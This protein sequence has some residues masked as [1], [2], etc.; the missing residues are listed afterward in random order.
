M[1]KIS[2]VL[3]TLLF[4]LSLPFYSNVAKAAE[5]DTIDMD[6]SKGNIVYTTSEG[7]TVVQ[8]GNTSFGI[9]NSYKIKDINLPISEIMLEASSNLT[10]RGFDV[11]TPIQI[12]YDDYSSETINLKISNNG[13]WS[14]LLIGDGRLVKNLAVTNGSSG[15]VTTV[16][17]ISI[18]LGNQSYTLKDSNPALS[19]PIGDAPSIGNDIL[20]LN[21]NLPAGF[22]PINKIVESVTVTANSWTAGFGVEDG[23]WSP[24]FPATI[25]FYID[26]YNYKNVDIPLNRFVSTTKVDIPAEYKNKVITKIKFSSSANNRIRKVDII[27]SEVTITS[28]KVAPSSITFTGPSI[29]QLKVMALMSTGETKDISKDPETEYDIDDA[30]VASVSETGLVTLGQAAQNGDTAV[31]EIQSGEVSATCNLKVVLT[32]T[33]SIKSSLSSVVLSN[34]SGKNTKQLKITA[35]TSSNKQIVVTNKATYKVSNT[36]YFKLSSTG[37]LTVL[38]AAP[39]GATG[40]ITVAYEGKMCKITIKVK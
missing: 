11:A 7:D 30:D 25:A 20:L 12:L 34:A 21:W 39:K 32:T 24:A 31:I 35:I 8:S 3:T 19:S 16:N 27:A 28:L 9:Y 10:E 29:T 2:I 38:P 17:K 15:N 13:Q 5:G 26:D 33:K 22:Y 23:N 1:K 14:K 37:L 18:K 4:I 6:L 40:Y 36:K